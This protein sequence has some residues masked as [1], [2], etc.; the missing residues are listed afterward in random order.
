MYIPLS[1]KAQSALEYMMTYGW[2][3]LIIVIVAVILYSMGIF[4]PSSSVTATSSG[5]SPFAVSSVVCNAAGLRIAIIAGGLPDSATSAE[6]TGIYFSSNTGT[7][8]VSSKLYKITPVN[9]A[10]GHSTTIIVPTIACTS[11]GTSFSLSTK[12]QY[13]Y[14]TPAGNV[15]ANATGTIAGK[16]SSTPSTTFTY[17]NMP[18]GTKWTVNYDNINK[19]STSNTISFSSVYGGNFVIYPVSVNGITYYPSYSAAQNVTA[20]YNFEVDFIPN[21]RPFYIG[22]ASGNNISI[23]YPYNLSAGKNISLPHLPYSVYGL[24]ESPNGSF[25]YTSTGNVVS[26]S[27]D[28]VIPIKNR[29]SNGYQGIAITPNGKYGYL[30]GSKSNQV[31]V[32]NTSSNTVI[33]NITV[34]LSPV[35]IA[36]TPN[37]QYAYVANSNSN[38]TSVIS[39]STNSI[40]TTISMTNAPWGVAVSP[41]GKY[42]YVSQ[43]NGT[44]ISVISTQTNTVISTIS[45]PNSFSPRG[46][47]VSPN[48]KYLFVS[49]GGG[50]FYSE[51]LCGNASVVSLQTNSV[52]KT[53]A[54][55]QCIKQ[56]AFS[57]NGKL[58][59]ATSPYGNPHDL[60]VIY[61]NLSYKNIT[62]AN[63]Y[64]ICSITNSP[65]GNGATC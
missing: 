46:L 17:Y 30:A 51:H 26:T 59:F 61:Q 53:L 45:T 13:S 9:L 41:N 14:S 43:F 27:T 19:T 60:H 48:S 57:P 20:G 50:Y 21:N 55:L 4:N 10:S 54:G 47:A 3:I 22:E 58:L 40:I 8:A 37:G 52:V 24:A 5:F 28:T 64:S 12:L 2:A 56:F 36:I 49:E 32:L 62:E 25:I 35:G 39:T 11:S 1:K 44:A 31:S 38:T 33:K 23:F 6:I 16:A 15:N 7:T 29:M 63:Y 42:V 18:S 34:G 65:I